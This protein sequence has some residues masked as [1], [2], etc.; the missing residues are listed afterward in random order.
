[1]TS[2]FY[3]KIFAADHKFFEGLVTD[4]VIPG[5]DGLIG[6]EAHHENM[7]LAVDVGDCHFVTADGDVIHALLGTGMCQVFNNRVTMFVDTAERPEQ[8]DTKRAEEALDRA[9]EKLRQKQ[10]MQEYFMTQASLARAL[11]RLKE[12]NKYNQQNGV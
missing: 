5:V 10:S 4:L 3:L 11:S 8:I 12:K 9:K 2:Q 1:M 7:V 6:V